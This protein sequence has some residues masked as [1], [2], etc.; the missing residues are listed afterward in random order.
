M[1]YAIFFCAALAGHPQ[2]KAC[3]PAGS[4]TF[5]TLEECKKAAK[6]PVKTDGPP[7]VYVCLLQ[8]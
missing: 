8:S 7:L 3:D 1:I 6:M 5:A 2:V 4:A